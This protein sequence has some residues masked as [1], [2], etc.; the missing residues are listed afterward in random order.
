M[1]LSQIVP[2][3]LNQNASVAKERFEKDYSELISLLQQSYNGLLLKIFPP[4]IH[5]PYP[6]STGHLFTQLLN[7]PAGA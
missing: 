6:V 5:S 1:S 2:Y 4:E 7:S 3:E